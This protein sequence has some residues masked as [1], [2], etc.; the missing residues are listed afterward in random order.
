MA[1]IKLANNIKE[2]AFHESLAGDAPVVQAACDVDVDIFVMIKSVERLERAY[3]RDFISTEC[4]E[5]A[6]NRLLAQFKTL[7][8]SMRDAVQLTH[9][10]FR[11]LCG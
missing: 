3:V 9:L 8:N 7:W 2:E 1:G 5:P 4:Y 10:K 11:N 6:C